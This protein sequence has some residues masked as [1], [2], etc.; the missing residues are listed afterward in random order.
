MNIIT[1]LYGETQGTAVCMSITS[2]RFFIQ[3]LV[4]RRAF[5]LVTDLQV[6]AYV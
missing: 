4:S 5:A 2:T 3:K 6:F 1:S